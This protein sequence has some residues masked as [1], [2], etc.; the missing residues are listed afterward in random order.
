MIDPESIQAGQCYLTGDAHVRR[1]V[2]I[3]PDGR[4]QYEW[5]G[6]N[7][8]KWKPGILD[9]REFALAAERSVPSDWT[10]ESDEE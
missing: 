6:G 2:R 1:V 9:Q 5:R 3:M 7:R 8:R 10:P 4:V